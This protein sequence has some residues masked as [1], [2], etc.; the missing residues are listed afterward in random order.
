MARSVRSTDREN[1]VALNNLSL[2]DFEPVSTGKRNYKPGSKLYQ[3]ERL[4]SKRKSSSK[5]V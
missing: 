1:Y 2:A 3:V 4:V 5:E